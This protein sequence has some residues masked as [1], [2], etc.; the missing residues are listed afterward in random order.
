MKTLKPPSTP[1]P[2]SS[3]RM[4]AWTLEHE[5]LL[6]RDD[7]TE[8]SQT[9][10]RRKYTPPPWKPSF[11]SFRVWGLCGVC[12][13][14]WTYGVCPFPCFPKDMVYTIGSIAFLLCDLGVRRQTERGRGCHGGGAYPFSPENCNLQVVYSL[15]KEGEGPCLRILSR[16]SFRREINRLV[17]SAGQRFRQ[18]V[19][20]HLCQRFRPLFKT[21]FQPALWLEK[22][23]DGLL[24]SLGGFERKFPEGG[25]DFLEVALVWKYPHG[26]LPKQ[27][28]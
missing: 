26:T 4:S 6:R 17:S 7:V 23:L 3:L 15:R 5:F 28:S 12:P 22:L 2:D 14:F 1:T 13:S 25:L 10:G 24:G 20:T 19:G 18:R 27:T 21:I 16:N 11:F 8:V 9:Q